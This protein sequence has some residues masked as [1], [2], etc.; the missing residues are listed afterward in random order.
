MTEKRQTVVPLAILLIGGGIMVIRQGHIVSEYSLRWGAE[1]GLTWPTVLGA[2]MIA[3]GGV[4]LLVRLF[5][6]MDSGD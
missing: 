5:K 1:Q 3:S 2:V 6:Y 4:L